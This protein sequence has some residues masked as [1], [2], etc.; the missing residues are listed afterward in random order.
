MQKD[1]LDEIQ[2]VKL[3]GNR[4]QPY[5]LSQLVLPDT[6]NQGKPV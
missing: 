6:H 4:K 3:L 2:C 1:E 5:S